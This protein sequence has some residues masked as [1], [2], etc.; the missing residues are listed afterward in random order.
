VNAQLA[1]AARAR[2][3][4]RDWFGLPSLAGHRPLVVSLVIDSLGDGLFVPFAI[5]YFLHTTRL[6]LPSIGLSLTIAGLVALPAVLP[7]GVLL[8]RVRPSAVVIAANLISAA[9]YAGYLVVG[10]AWQLVVFALLAG[11]GGRVYWTA[12]LGLIGDGFSADR[13]R[14]FALQRALRNAGYGLGGILG[15]LTITEAGTAGYHALAALNALSYMVAAAL[16]LRWSARQP[17]MR[18]T[19][20]A[21]RA[22]AAGHGD[23]ALAAARGGYRTALSDW[24]FMLITGANL[25]FVL[26]MM[27]PSVLLAL[28]VI[29]FLH[30]PAWLVGALLAASTVM[31][32]LGQ[33]ALSRVVDR[34]KPT[35]MLRL[36]AAVWAA[37]FV[38]FWLVGQVPRAAVFAGLLTAVT[39]FTVAEMIQGPALNNLVVAI[40]PDRLRGRYLG[41]YQLSWGLGRAVAPAAFSWMFATSAAL[42]WL[43]LAVAC[44]ACAVGLGALGRTG[45]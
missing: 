33:T 13:Q 7:A 28:Y 32:G 45:G 31:I 14:W 25:L 11:V 10:R 30:E 23:G 20:T 41:V 16:V 4:R 42:P 36:T 38:L 22:A 2:T 39:V 9:G 29:R 1:Q 26:C 44:A 21:R 12:N 6:S 3:G 5:V 37:A 34:L 27:A 15:A 24:T 35:P 8:D 40:A 18:R 43:A 17:A 19:G